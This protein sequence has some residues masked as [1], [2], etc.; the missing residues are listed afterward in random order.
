MMS[1]SKILNVSTSKNYRQFKFLPMNREL[2]SKQVQNLMVSTRKMGI[3]RNV[4][5]CVTDCVDG[6][7]KRWVVDG[8]HLLTVC[9]RED[10]AVPYVTI[11]VKDEFDLV[12]QMALLNNSSKS[13]TL[14]NYVVA[15]KSLIPDYAKLFK[16]KNMY[17][18]EPLML[19]AIG[20]N[21]MGNLAGMSKI[22]KT[23]EFVISNPKA[24]EMCKAFND[25]FLAVGPADRWVKKQF[26]DVFLVKYSVYNHTKTLANIKKHIAKIKAM[27][28]SV[29]AHEFIESKIFK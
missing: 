8:Q 17:D 4:V 16:W 11:E 3:T 25:I 19:A 21:G 18:I 1:K 22:L 14:M 15:F 2:D 20:M 6:V 7:K 24:E 9:E 29:N 13:W 28:S 5:T 23:G 26:L 27:S 10:I 12:M